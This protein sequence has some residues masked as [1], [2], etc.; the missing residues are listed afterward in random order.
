[1]DNSQITDFLGGLGYAP[2]DTIHI[3]LL[4]AKGFNPDSPEH[5]ALFPN[6]A[7][8]REH[9]NGAKAWVPSN[10]N[11]K[12]HDGALIWQCKKG[13]RPIKCSDPWEWIQ[14]QS[15]K[16]FCPYIVVNPGGQNKK[17]I[18]TGRVAFW[19]HDE[20]DK[21]TQIE[22]FMEYADRWGG[23]MAVETRSSIHCYIR[24]DQELPPNLIQP[25][26]STR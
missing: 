5:R 23:A 26:P 10:K 14:A 22:R 15:L 21:P 25:T 13:D 9:R 24:L 2:D 3:R 4:P 1:M 11:L 18:T 20:L 19:E 6:L 17:E 16:G 12:L 8:E 7:Y